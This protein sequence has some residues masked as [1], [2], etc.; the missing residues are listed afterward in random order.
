MAKQPWSKF[1]WDDWD[2]DPGLRLCS[3]AAQGLWMRMLCICAR[4]EPKGYLAIQDQ[5]L[6]VDHIARLAGVSET[7]AASM[8]D[9]LDRFGVFSRDR[10]GRIYSRRMVRDVK[11][12]NEG[13]KSVNKRWSQPPENNDE[14]HGP[15]R[16]ANRNPSTK[17]LEARYQSKEKEETYVSSKKNDPPPDPDFSMQEDPPRMPSPP[18]PDERGLRLPTDWQPGE[19]ERAYAAEKGFSPGQIAELAEGFGDHWHAKPG[20]DG[21]KSNWSLAWN[22]WVRNDIKFH[23]EPQG[24]EQTGGLK[25]A[26]SRANTPQRRRGADDYQ[27]DDE[28]RLAAIRR[29]RAEALGRVGGAHTAADGDYAGACFDGDY[30]HV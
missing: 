29:G 14:N 10:K 18:K 19:A 23:G 20:K 26:A 15:N 7:E 12:S 13:R 9:E 16:G 17:K 3:L 1:F 8:I 5:A 22:T 2:S 27:L 21:R 11:K 4:H 24:R 6:T 25:H 28:A 30:R